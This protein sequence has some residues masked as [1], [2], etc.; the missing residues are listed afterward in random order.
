M[1]IFTP[2]DLPI[3]K[4]DNWNVFW[5]IWYTY[6]KPLIKQKMNNDFSQVGIGYDSAWIGLDIF[7]R[8]PDN[9]L[10]CYHAPFY[11][12]SKKLPIMYKFLKEF[13][14]ECFTVRLCQSIKDIP[15]HTDDNI[16]QWSLRAYF[17][18][19]ANTQQWYFTKPHDRYGNK[20]YITLPSSTNWFMY[21]DK[22]VWHGTDYNQVHSK[23][24]LQVFSN[25][26]YNLL[27]QVSKEKYSRYTLKLDQ[28]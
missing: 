3:I 24:L 22:H 23:I 5:D 2:V 27:A 26:S 8:T 20:T 6:S 13:D 10:V 9:R 12:I 16:D 17:F 25:N 19:T 28:I 21:N 7:K 4:P 1:I 18:Y 11:D 14:T 15:S